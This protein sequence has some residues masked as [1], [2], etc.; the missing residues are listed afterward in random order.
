MTEQT[1]ISET[2]AE[3]PAQIIQVGRQPILDVSLNTYGYELLYRCEDQGAG[4]EFVDGNLATAKTVLNSFLDFGLRRLA[5]NA[6][7]FINLTRTFLIELKP[8]PVEKDNLVLEV[9]ENIDIDDELVTGV[10]TLYDQGY[11]IALDD[12]RFEDRWRPLLPYCHI[13]KV[14]ILGLDLI[15]FAEQIRQLKQQGIILL[16]EKV[17]DQED[18]QQTKDLGFDLFQGY[19]FSKPETLSTSSLRSNQALILKTLAKI[20]DPDS[21]IDE[22]SSLV[23]RDHNLSIKILRFINSASAGLPRQVDSIQQA[24]TFVGLNKLRTWATIFMLAGLENSTPELL[25]VG[26]VRA[27]FCQLVVKQLKLGDPDSGYT[28]GLLSVLD[29]LFNVPMTELIKELSL[30]DDMTAAL[31]DSSGPYGKVLKCSRA[32]EQNQ[33]DSHCADDIPMEQLSRLYLQ[34]LI[35]TEEMQKSLND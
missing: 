5:G 29:G 27:E 11:T 12:Y 26:L 9:L 18:F 1:T 15:Q 21:D 20:N 6:K 13:I 2:V 7:V 22:L 17:E 25:T 24:V 33:W 16:A 19:F 14:D 3:C 35:V 31:T 30:S 32:L 34:A 10:K 4:L 28:V 8:L 23:A